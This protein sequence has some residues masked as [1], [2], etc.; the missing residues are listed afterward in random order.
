[1]SCNYIL[2]VKIS[3]LMI[4]KIYSQSDNY[5]TFQVE[6]FQTKAIDTI[7]PLESHNRKSL[8]DYYLLWK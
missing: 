3:A 2:H 1:M 6:S 7:W 5:N 8:R 4:T